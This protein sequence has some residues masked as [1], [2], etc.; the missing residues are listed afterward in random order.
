MVPKP[1]FLP[2]FSIT[3]LLESFDHFSVAHKTKYIVVFIPIKNMNINKNMS[4]VLQH[5]QYMNVNMNMNMNMNINMDM[6]MDMDL[7]NGQ[8]HGHGYGHRQDMDMDMD[9]NMGMDMDMNNDKSNISVA[10]LS[11]RYV[12]FPYSK[13]HGIPRHLVALRDKKFRIVPRNLGI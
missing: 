6:D 5:V 7:D 11:W 12:K 1:Y 13:N 8:E 2:Y 3:H 9:K 10:P 4:K